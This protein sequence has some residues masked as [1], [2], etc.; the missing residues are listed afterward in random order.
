MQSLGHLGV[1]Y[2]DDRSLVPCRIGHRF[3]GC[4][5]DGAAC[6]GD[7]ANAASTSPVCGRPRR[8]CALGDLQREAMKANEA[9]IVHLICFAG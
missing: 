1:T 6:A 9:L 2:R 4:P 3:P 8:H 7:A 5:P